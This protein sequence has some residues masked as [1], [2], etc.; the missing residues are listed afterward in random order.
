MFHEASKLNIERTW[1]QALTM[2][3]NHQCCE[4]RQSHHP[5]HDFPGVDCKLGMCLSPRHVPDTIGCLGWVT[6]PFCTVEQPPL[7]QPGR[8]WTHLEALCYNQADA[9]KPSAQAYAAVTHTATWLPPL[10]LQVN[11]LFTVSGTNHLNL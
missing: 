6:E 7:G 11:T 10:G 4:T 9:A 5:T 2:V 1:H 3:L 8:H